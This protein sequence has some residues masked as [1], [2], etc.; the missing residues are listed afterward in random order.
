VYL[1]K[2]KWSELINYS[3]ETD[4]LILCSV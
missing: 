2:K 4:V 3:I 1:K